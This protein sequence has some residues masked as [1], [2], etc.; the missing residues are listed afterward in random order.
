M[1]ENSSS[2]KWEAEAF[3]KYTDM[4]GKIPLF[5]RQIARQ[6]VDKKALENALSRGAQNVEE[7]DILKAFF[8][9]IPKSL[10]SMMIRLMET[11]GFDY[12]KYEK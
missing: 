10:Y 1:A 9:E 11:V 5:H 12:R 6:V 4:I 3:R 2:L 7:E 8:S